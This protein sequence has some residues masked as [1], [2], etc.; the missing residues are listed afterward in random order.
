MFAFFNHIYLLLYQWKVIS[1]K[2]GSSQGY[3]THGW[4]FGELWSDAHNLGKHAK[5]LDPGQALPSTPAPYPP[6]PQQNSLLHA[7]MRHK[8]LS[9]TNRA[10]LAWW[11]E[12]DP[13]VQRARHARRAPGKRHREPGQ[14]REE[15]RSSP[16][17][18]MREPQLEPAQLLT[19]Q[20]QQRALPEANSRVLGLEKEWRPH[21][22]G[23]L[24]GIFRSQGTW[25]QHTGCTPTRLTQSCLVTRV[26]LGDDTCAHWHIPNIFGGKKESTEKSI[27]SRATVWHVSAT[28][29]QKGE[30][31]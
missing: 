9:K 13:W 17:V 29:I 30:F 23:W 20:R 7:F 2:T 26:V 31:L 24:L 10:G 25:M 16:G 27:M 6:S 4:A 19:A 22:T 5:G 18:S 15:P 14:A 28:L 21:S 12:Q 1:W 8:D 3:T 11:P